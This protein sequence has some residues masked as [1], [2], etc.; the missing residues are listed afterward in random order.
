MLCCLKYRDSSC[1]PWGA[2]TLIE[3]G[4]QLP[5]LHLWKHLCLSC[6]ASTQMTLVGPLCGFTFSFACSYFKQTGLPF[7]AQQHRDQFP[8]VN[9]MPYLDVLGLPH[10]QELQPGVGSLIWTPNSQPPLPGSGVLDAP[11]IQIPW[12]GTV[13]TQG[14]AGQGQILERKYYSFENCKGQCRNC[15]AEESHGLGSVFSTC[16]FV[17]SQGLWQDINWSPDTRSSSLNAMPISLS[18]SWIVIS[19]WR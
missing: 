14:E 2:N 4:S 8:L 6:P 18:G 19:Q 15:P 3:G 1:F 10:A 7:L 16:S 17:M 13:L 11:R 12:V 9:Q 5:S